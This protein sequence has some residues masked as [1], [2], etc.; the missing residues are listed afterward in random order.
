MNYL[1]SII[2]PTYNSEN[3]IAKCLESLISQTYKNIE[4]LIINDG[5]TDKTLEVLNGYKD[6]RLKIIDKKN[7]GVSDSRNLG[8]EK[9]LG[10]YIVF[11]DSDDFLDLD[12]IYDLNN[13]IS[14]SA[15]VFSGI[16]RIVNNAESI[17]I[18]QSNFNTLT[19]E[20]KL[21]FIIKREIINA[22]FNKIYSRKILIEKKIRFNKEIS[23]GEDLL[24]NFN[25]LKFVTSIKFTEKYSY[26]YYIGNQESLSRKIDLNKYEELAK[27]I[28]ELEFLNKWDISD[29]LSYIRKK[30][31]CSSY[32]NLIYYKEKITINDLKIQILKINDAFKVKKIQKLSLS[33]IDFIMIIIKYTNINVLKVIIFMIRYFMGLLFTK[34]LQKK[35]LLKKVKSKKRNF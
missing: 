11:V 29:E 32:K 26:N 5:S 2:V 34:S 35:Y 18:I 6:S 13:N 10:E 25:Y 1:I 15:F 28:D 3:Y 14:E 27:V 17:R 22:S 8:I 9:A 19:F 12:H 31:I 33:K 7:T 23:I 24:F 21:K 16:K 20:E 30:N 4:I